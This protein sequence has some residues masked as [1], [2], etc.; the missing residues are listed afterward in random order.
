MEARIVGNAVAPLKAM[1]PV[2]PDEVGVGAIGVIG[3]RRFWLRDENGRLFCSKRDGRLL[4]IH[5][6]WDEASRR[7]ALAF[8][9][10]RLVEGC[11]E[12][13]EQVDA[14]IFG[15]LRLSRQVRGG[16]W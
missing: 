11:V 8:P 10:G 2:H 16:S 14:T 4:Q 1:A 12:L 5:P 3:N 6:E 13:G 9:D 15:E 7:L